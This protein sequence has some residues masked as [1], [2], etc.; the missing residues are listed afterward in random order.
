MEIWQL[1]HA[2]YDSVKAFAE[3][4]EKLKWLDV[5][6]ENA[7]VLTEDESI[8]IGKSSVSLTLSWGESRAAQVHGMTCT[9]VARMAGL[10]DMAPGFATGRQIRSREL[11]RTIVGL[12]LAAGDAVRKVLWTQGI[13]ILMMG[14]CND[15]GS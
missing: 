9:Q 3:R 6:R 1:E 12:I 8:D 7:G 11:L 10:A 5:L 13:R 14:L 4:A 2:S 15:V